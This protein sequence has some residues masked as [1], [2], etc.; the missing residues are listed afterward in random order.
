AVAAPPVQA[1]AVAAPV[2]TGAVASGAVASGAVASRPAAVA[3]STEGAVAAV[4]AY[5]DALRA[6]DVA[7]AYASWSDGGRASGRS[8]EQFAAGAR[9]QAIQSVSV[10][11]PARS[12]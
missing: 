7:R 9:A 5:Y 2:A 3:P 4:R 10:G 12:G 6:G 11:E 8:P 1:P